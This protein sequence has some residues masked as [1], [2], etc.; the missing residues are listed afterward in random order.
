MLSYILKPLSLLSLPALHKLGAGLG[1]VL[2][3][4]L[5]K[6]KAETK[7]NM[8]QSGLFD[9][10]I[11]QAVRDYFTFY[12]QSILEV[13]Y[14]W[15]CNNHKIERL[16]D[17]RHE[18]DSIKANVNH[19]KGIIFLTLHMGCFEVT[20]LH[21]GL[22]Q[23]ITVLYR[24]PKQ[25]SVQKVM[26]SGRKRK[27]V[28]L[29]PANAKG[30]R[31]LFQALKRGEAIGILPDQVPKAG[32]GEWSDFFNKPAYT[33]TLVSKL[34]KK[35]G[36]SVVIGFAER[37]KDGKGFALHFSELDKGAVDTPALLNKAVEAQ[38]KAK[39]EQYIWSYR[40]FK[41]SRK[42]KPLPTSQD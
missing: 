41:S 27:N 37:L 6:V 39:P 30:V 12:G 21:Y 31:M 35:T 15:Q 26:E 2:F 14:I 40:R 25:Q 38:V 9:D 36:A 33:M 22:N 3:H 34:A 16:I 5:P 28:A 32:E 24:E 42:S 20:S 18:W 11:D 8:L 13:P 19:E 17:V 1:W 7:N 23:K 4:T 29:A 10:D